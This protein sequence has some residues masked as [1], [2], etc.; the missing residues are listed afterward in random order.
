M[1]LQHSLDGHLDA[2]LEQLQSIESVALLAILQNL[3]IAESFKK[4]LCNQLFSSIGCFTL[5]LSSPSAQS[6]PLDSSKNGSF[7]TK[8]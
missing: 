5:R 2:R 6:A 7:A 1:F 3:S 4:S 8:P